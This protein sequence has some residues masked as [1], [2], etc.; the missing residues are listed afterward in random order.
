MKS[1]PT[2]LVMTLLLVPAGCRVDANRSGSSGAAVAQTWT[3][4]ELYFGMSRPNGGPDVMDLE[5]QSFLDE[6]VTPRFPDGFTVLRADGQW[7]EQSQRIAKE[8][9]RVLVI[10]RSRTRGDDAKIEQIRNEYKTRFAQEAVLRVDDVQ[11][12]SL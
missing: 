11:R 10:F 5:F 2:F 7:R 3:R 4:T 6:I 12:V 1:I 9:S 8:R